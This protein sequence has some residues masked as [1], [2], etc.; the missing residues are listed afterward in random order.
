MIKSSPQ[1]RLFRLFYVLL[2]ILGLGCGA[3]IEQSEPTSSVG[4]PATRAMTFEEFI[5]QTYREKDNEAYIVDGDILVPDAKALRE[6]YETFIAHTRTPQTG[7]HGALVVHRD[8]GA[9]ARWD[10]TQKRDLRYCVSTDFAANYPV[11]VDAIAQAARDWEQAADIRFIHVRAEDGRC[12]AGNTN[13]LFD[14]RPTTGEAYLARAFF[15][16]H[17]RA[18]RNILINSTAFAPQDPFTLQGVLRHEIGHAL[19]F[20]HE[21]IRP[22]AK[23]AACLKDEWSPWT[24]LTPYDPNSVM[25]YPTCNGTNRGDFNLTQLDRAGVAILYGANGVLPPAACGSLNQACCNGTA[26]NAGLSCQGGSCRVPPTSCGNVG[27]AC[28]GTACNGG[29]SCQSGT[30]RSALPAPCGGKDEVCCGGTAC[31][32]GLSCQSGTCKPPP[33]P[34]GNCYLFVDSNYKGSMLRVDSDLNDLHSLGMGDKVSSLFCDPGVSVQVFMDRHYLGTSMVL[35]GSI[36]SLHQPV[37]GSLGDNI[38]S[39]RLIR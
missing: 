21:H 4:A 10:D 33:P 17:A 34:S 16:N 37:Y 9:D 13:V 25:H 24:P 36:P 2:F 38:S 15:P 19:G 1:L 27:E 32:S 23:A 30:C 7:L 12:T 3:T 22:E 18:D 31:N 5:A 11:A 8:N 35:T 20:R 28:C 39:L 6:F 26:C 14:V 29:L